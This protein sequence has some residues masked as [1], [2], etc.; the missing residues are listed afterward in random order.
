MGSYTG[1]DIVPRIY[2]VERDRGRWA[3]FTEEI[4]TLY[5]DESRVTEDE[6]CIRFN[7]GG[8]R[9]TIPVLGKWFVR[10]AAKGPAKI[11]L[12]HVTT[13]AV[14]IWGIRIKVFD[15]GVGKPGYYTKD[16]LERDEP[17]PNQVDPPQ[18]TTTGPEGQPPSPLFEIREVRGKGRGLVA[19]VDL[20]AG[21]QI[22]SEKPLITV[23]RISSIDMDEK[24]IAAKLKTLPKEQQRQFFSLRNSIDPKVP[25]GGIIQTNGITCSDLLGRTVPGDTSWEDKTKGRNKEGVYPTICLVNHS[26]I[27]NCCENWDYEAGVETV[28]TLRPIFAG[29]EL[30]FAYEHGEMFAQRQLTMKTMFG[31]EC[32][33]DF[34]LLPPG[35]IRESDANRYMMNHLFQL[36]ATRETRLNDPRKILECYLALLQIM[37]AEYGSYPDRTKL[38]VYYGAFDIVISHGDRARGG[39]FAKRGYDMSLICEGENSPGTKQWKT[40]MEK[41]ERHANYGALSMG[42]KRKKLAYPKDLEGDDFEKWVFRAKLGNTAIR[43][44]EDSLPTLACRADS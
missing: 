5:R 12:Q 4:R 20:P 40:L 36:L 2:D 11:Y 22:L 6:F 38:K 3:R 26:C 33:C 15:E 17:S 44:F 7:Y 35:E 14:R 18:S 24:N 37:D 27:P 9:I 1:F 10:F 29:E 31:F 28:Y 39:L 23:N 25:L 13:I 30:T 34:C 21:K 32:K 16:E 41:P 42:W 8:D 43:V 19:L